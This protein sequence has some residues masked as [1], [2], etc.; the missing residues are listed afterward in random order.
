MVRVELKTAKFSLIREE[1][2]T[3]GL[4]QNPDLSEIWFPRRSPLNFTKPRL[5]SKEKLDK[6]KK[7]Q[8]LNKS[9]L[10]GIYD[11][12]PSVFTTS[13][14]STNHWLSEDECKCTPHF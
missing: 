10:A 4:C 7:N 8:L 14:I 3:R 13:T 2:E 12:R 1:N 11:K 9:K 5:F 6:K